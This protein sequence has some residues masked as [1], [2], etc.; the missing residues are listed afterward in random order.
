MNIETIAR[1][2]NLSASTVSRALRDCDGVNPRTRKRVIKRAGELGY[3]LPELNKPHGVAL[4]IPG[5]SI[6]DAH[7]LAHRYMVTIGSEV[8]KLGWQLYMLAVPSLE[9]SAMDDKS[10]WPKAL[11]NEQIDCCITIDMV[12][13][14]AR[15]LLAEH[16]SQNVV[17]ISRF[18]LEDGISGVAIA[19]YIYTAII[20]PDFVEEYTAYSIENLKET[21]PP[22]K[23][24]QKKLELENE[25]KS[26]DSSGILA[27]VM[28]A[29]VVIIGF[30]I[31]LI[32]ALILQRKQ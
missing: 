21:V 14:K 12:T 4:L 7:E 32:S 30:I 19:D 17:M 9:S 26:M 10:K 25:V 3:R 15:K 27:F 5:S 13:P 22:E 6:E 8:S 31:S 28:F 24:E 18:Y 20:N 11:F 23:F 2:L 1:K 29:T 16:F